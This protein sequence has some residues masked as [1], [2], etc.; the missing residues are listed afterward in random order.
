PVTGPSE[1]QI[2]PACNWY[3]LFW[4][5]SDPRIVDWLKAGTPGVPA[6]YVPKLVFKLGGF[7]PTIGGAPFHF[8]APP[9][10]P[11]PFTMD[12]IGRERPGELS[13]RGGYWISAP[14]NTIKLAFSS[15]SLISGDATGAVRAAPGSQWATLL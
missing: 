7:D 6:V 9:P 11:S 4:L 5:A 15:D 12:D 13:V 3:L 10:T 1:G 14:P 8:Q 2:P